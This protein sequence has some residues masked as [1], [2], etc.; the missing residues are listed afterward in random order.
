MADRQAGAS[1]A[2]LSRGGDAGGGGFL[3]IL[4]AL[5]L[6][7]RVTRSVQIDAELRQRGRSEQR[8]QAGQHF[9][10]HLHGAD[11]DRTRLCLQCGGI[12]KLHRRS[13]W[14]EA[15]LQ[16]SSLRAARMGSSRES[17]SLTE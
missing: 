4:H 16:T 14:N 7:L 9:K 8:D 6:T 3:A 5:N 13:K 17:V 2:A 1:A 10:Q 12:V 11:N 15:G